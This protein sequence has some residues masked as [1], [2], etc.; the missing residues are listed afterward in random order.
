MEYT[1]H[2]GLSPSLTHSSTRGAGTQPSERLWFYTQSNP[3]GPPV[4]SVL[5]VAQSESNPGGRVI[6]EGFPGVA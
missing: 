1:L 4:S 5:T 3:Q 2:A 6:G